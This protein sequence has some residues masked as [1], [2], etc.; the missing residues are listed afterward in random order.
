MLTR[1]LHKA[2]TGVMAAAFAV[3]GPAFAQKAEKFPTK[4]VRI[5]VGFSAGSATD[6]TA[7]LVGPKLADLWGQPVVIENRSG[8]GSTLASTAVAQATPDGHTLLMISTSFAITATIQKNLPY[9]AR[10]DFRGVTQ[11]GT[12]TGVVSVAPSLGVKSLKE[13]IALVKER[14]GKILYGSTGAGSGIHMSTERF[15][16][17][18]GIRP[19]H[20]AFKGQPE[21]I[22]EVV[23]GR[24]NFAIPS[25]GPA[26]SFIKEGR[27]VPLAV[28]TPKRSPHLPDVPTILEILPQF[29]RDSTHG[30][31]AHSRTPTPIVRQIARDVA[32]VLELPDVK[33]RMYAMSFDPAPTTPE[34]YDEIIR[35]QFET[36]ARVAKAVGLFPK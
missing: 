14:P 27:L 7:R 35:K 4:P 17:V 5:V 12:P 10:K 20:V 31:L 33:E 3:A 29:E 1:A 6:I 13:L 2:L 30:F 15:N 23:T 21:M 9:D 11:I 19:Q 18:A 28:N 34:E 16:L 8:A 26:M 24:V 32:R 25:L 36:F 22:I